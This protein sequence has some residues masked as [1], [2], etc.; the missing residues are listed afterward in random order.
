VTAAVVMVL[1]H[2]IC[3]AKILVEGNR[4]IAIYLQGQPICWLR[5]EP[6]D[7]QNTAMEILKLNV[8]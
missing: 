3:H 5:F 2:S 8:P 1:I 4:S 7:F 6:E